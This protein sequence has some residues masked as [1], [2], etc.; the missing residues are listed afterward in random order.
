MAR[1]D[2]AVRNG[3]VV[4]PYLGTVRADV[5]IRAGRIAALADEVPAADADQ[6]IDARGKLVLPGAVDSHY[7]IGIYRPLAEDA[8]SETCSSL[9]GGVTTVLS[10][11]RTGQH[12][13]NRVGPYREIFPEVLGLIAGRA[14]TDYGFHLAIMTTAQLDEVDWLVAEQGVTSFK[15]YL[16][17]KGLNLAADSTRA[18]EYTMA[19]AYDLG[20]LYRLMQRVAAAADRHGARG[21]VS[22][23]VHCENA[24]LIRTFIEEVQR[25]ETQDLGAYHRARPPL[26]ERL[27][28]QEVITLA[29]ATGCP[30]NL[31]HLSSG[32]ALTAGAKARRDHPELDVRLET[33]LHHLTLT[34]ETAGGLPGKVNPPIRTAEDVEALWQGVRSGEIDTVA[35]DH[36][37]CPIALK[38]DQLWPAMPGFG[39]SALLYPLLVSEGYH[40]RGLPL[41]RVVELASANPARSF[42]LYPRKGS[43]APGCD[44]DLAVLDPE[45]EATVSPELLRSAQEYTP[46]AGARIKGWITHTIL[47]GQVVFADGEPVG[48]PRGR[49]LKRPLAAASE[50]RAEV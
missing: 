35:S 16:F 31:L 28:I 3:T 39:G 9:V 29:E 4:L 32:E 20:H 37:C 13:L 48:P 40:R 33:T 49:Y 25:E 44:A 7:H 45:R 30:V 14:Y 26:A 1:Y 11:F 5:A 50:A 43:I 38:G 27:A 22:L 23:S 12:Y 34:Y 8:E 19:D 15:F 21:R 42:G 36:A 6:V 18:S 17:Y 46:F 10:Y 47:G 24:E 2:L 41:Q